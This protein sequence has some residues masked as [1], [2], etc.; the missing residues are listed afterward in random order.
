[1]FKNTYP[2]T[3]EKSSDGRVLVRF[4]DFGWGVTDGSGREEAF[5]EAQ[6]CLRTI[7]ATHMTNGEKVPVPS[8]PARGQR[9]VPVPL[10]LAPKLALY[11]AITE[12]G[13]TGS[14]LARKMGLK[15]SDVSK[16]LDP[17]KPCRLDLLAE[18][19]GCLG[20][21]LTVSIDDAA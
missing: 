10:D 18:A 8:R 11:L 16:M 4:P 7:I 1:M 21:Q 19:L 13:L 5:S 6:D 20:K 3:F 2:A 15:E 14:G 9:L 12:K 17:R